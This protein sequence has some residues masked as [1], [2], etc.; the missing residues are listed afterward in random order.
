[1]AN[2]QVLS[3][4]LLLC[5]VFF[6]CGQSP[7]VEKEMMEE[8]DL[9]LVNMAGICDPESYDLECIKSEETKLSDE[10]LDMMGDIRDQAV[11]A[12][13]NE[14]SDERQEEYGEEMKD[15]IE[16]QFPVISGHA[17]ES[18]LRGLMRKLLQ[19][20]EDP[21]DIQYNIYVVQSS[22]VNAFTLGGEIF[23]TNA[24]LSESGSID[25]LACVIG[26]EIG[27]N[28][29]GHIANKIK[30]R[31]I[32]EGI[33]GE[34]AGE[35]VANVA[36]MLTM[37]FNQINEAESDVY[38]IDLAISSGYDP[39]RGIDFWKRMKSREGTENDIDNLMRSHP[40]SS[41]RIKCYR[42]HLSNHHQ[43]NCLKQ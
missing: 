22:Q 5:G 18:M 42:E 1:M 10:M 26:H 8:E 17:K 34:E 6:S 29:L 2:W 4:L 16:K 39:C 33:F 20:R 43:R 41:R 30:E 12:M 27:H 9:T 24:L 28:E 36:G 14:V 38:G 11:D 35:M 19:V 25:E 31:E 7:E 13:G 40:Y 37:G 23:V 32:A 15:E 21:S 3:K